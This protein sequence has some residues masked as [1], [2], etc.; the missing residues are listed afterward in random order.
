LHIFI[1]NY[2]E[3]NLEIYPYF[4]KRHHEVLLITLIFLLQLAIYESIPFFVTKLYGAMATL[5]VFEI[6]DV[7]EGQISAEVWVPITKKAIMR[8]LILYKPDGT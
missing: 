8:I 7:K 4:I 1:I 6:L 5:D 2:W 3:E